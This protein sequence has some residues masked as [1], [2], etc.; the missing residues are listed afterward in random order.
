MLRITASTS[1]KGAQSYYTAGLSRQDYYSEG[2]KITGH[3]Q[4]RGAAML[5]ISGEVT[6]EDFTMLTENLHPVTG[7][8]LTARQKDNR[9]VGYDFTFNAPK[10]VSLLYGMTG[11]ERIKDVFEQAVQGTLAEIEAGMKA[12]VRKGGAFEDRTTGNMVAASFMHFLARPVDG[13]PDPHLHSHNFVFNATWDPVEWQWKAG[14]F[15]GVHLDR[16]YYEAAFHARLAVGMRALGFE[17]ERQGKWWDVAGLSKDSLAKFSRRTAQIEAAAQAKGITDPDRKGELGARTRV[18]K[19]RDLD[20]DAL[21]AIWRNRMS[22]QDHEALAE[23]LEQA[24]GTDGT[25]DGT[26]DRPDGPN[27]R[28]AL[29]HAVGLLFARNSVVSEKQ[30]LEEAL[31]YGAGHVSPEDVKEWRNL[32][33]SNEM[34]WAD[35]GGRRLVTTREVLAEEQAMLAFARDGRGTCTPFGLGRPA[36]RSARLNAGQEA[37]VRHVLDSWDRVMLIRGVAGTGKTTLIQEAAAEIEKR[38]GLKVFAFAPSAPASRGEL[39]RVGFAQANTVEHLLINEVMQHRVKGQVLWIDEG[40]LLGTRD[41]GRLFGLAD[42]LGCRVVL[43]GDSKQH[44]SPSRGDALRLLETHAGVRP[45][46]VTEIIRQK[47]AYKEAVADLAKGDAASGFEQLDRLGW[48]I[49]A[50]DEVRAQLIAEDYAW[51]QR[52]GKTALVV[53]PTHRE[54]EEVTARIRE[55]LRKDGMLGTE[56]RPFFT[57]RNLHWTDAEKADAAM[58]RTGQVVQFVQ[59]APKIGNG[60]RFRV[61]GVEDGQVWM[62]GRGGRSIALPVDL[63]PR[64]Q[65]YEP[66]VLKLAAGDLIRI[67]HKGK[68]LDGHTMENGATYTVAGVTSQGNIQLS[69]GW[70]VGEGYAHLASGFYSTSHSS[71][72]KTVDRVLIAQSSASFPASSQEQFYVSASRG[73]EGVRIY[74]DDKEALC[75]HIVRSGQRGSATE[76]LGR[77]LA[78]DA[79]PRALAEMRRQMRDRLRRLQAHARRRQLIIGEVKDRLAVGAEHARGLWQER[80][81]DAGPGIER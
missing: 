60:E 1:A 75:G 15:H 35:V 23:V 42:R 71:Q 40:G 47:G 34:L 25:T 55:E 58:Y 37:A 20:M 32:L 9:R 80:V 43:S 70:E 26:A 49:E 74:T 4:G 73:R 11:D 6:R 77:E 52:A 66:N 3:W 22:A 38:S 51:L 5:G 53:A 63:A 39:R 10:G 29:R 13:E 46:Q 62:E 54:G 72:G 81:R 28:D 67:T 44:T 68:T 41:M 30:L 78:A 50:P 33:P 17:I 27:V 61:T 8:T 57:L 59:N 69:N 21:R 65:V 18:H 7:E 16:P 2:Q 14:E 45:A 56:E 19:G 79:K 64:F 24:F 36:Y 31:R 12:R 48:V 76:L